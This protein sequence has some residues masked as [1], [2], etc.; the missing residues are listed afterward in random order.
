MVVGA[1]AP[2]GF[3]HRM[4]QP[5]IEFVGRVDDVRG[6]L[7]RY[8]VFVCPILSGSG[9]RV[10]LLEAFAAGMAVVSTTIGA[11]GL[12]EPGSDYLEL[13]DDAKSFAD[14][15]CGLLA[16]PVRSRAMAQRA[17]REVEEKWDMAVVARKLEQ[18]YRDVLGAKAKHRS[19]P[20]LEPFP[21][22][23]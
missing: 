9:V 23:D 1:Q 13:A 22:L 2:P 4:A 15:V 19:N 10:K 18:H 5:G 16:D 3:E 14:R 7:G 17:R 21:G 11:E 20:D 12:A 6:V 8:A